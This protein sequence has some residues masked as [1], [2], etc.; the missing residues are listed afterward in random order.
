MYVLLLVLL[1]IMSMFYLLPLFLFL[2]IQVA[3]AK[4]SN[5]INQILLSAVGINIKSM[6]L[7]LSC[8]V[9]YLVSS[10]VCFIV[11]AVSM[12]YLLS[13]FL[14][15]PIQVAGVK[16]SNFINQI[17]LSA[18]GINIWSN[19]VDLMWLQLSYIVYY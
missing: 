17:L 15:L 13:L 14:F 7:H 18:I 5:F 3:G 12:F 4:M 1:V 9:Y 11:G 8:I 2:L 6:Q 10:H 16:M 19:V